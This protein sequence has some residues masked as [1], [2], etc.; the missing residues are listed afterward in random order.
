MGGLGSLMFTSIIARTVA[1]HLLKNPALAILIQLRNDQIIVVN[2]YFFPHWKNTTIL[3]IWADLEQYLQDLIVD[4]VIIGRGLNTRIGPGG[5]FPYDSS[6]DSVVITE[7]IPTTSTAP[8]M[9]SWD[10]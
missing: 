1:L 6:K 10:G 9:P 7:Y 2:I 4:K 8:K 3:V 5:Q